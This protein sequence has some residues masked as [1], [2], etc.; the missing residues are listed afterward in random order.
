M[1]R[2]QI[3]R[4]HKL[5]SASAAL[6]AF[7]AGVVMAPASAVSAISVNMFGAYV[8]HTNQ[9]VASFYLM[10]NVTVS[11][12]EASDFS[13]LGSATGCTIEDYFSQSSFHVIN[14]SNCSEGTL[15]LQ[16]GANSVSDGN[17]NWGPELGVVS[18]FMVIDRIAPTIAFGPASS[19]ISGDSINFVA[20]WNEQVSLV[21]TL[22]APAVSGAGCNITSASQ[23]GSSFSFAITACQPGAD[24][25]VTVFANSY[26][27][28]AGNLGPAQDVVS[29]AVVVAA[30]ALPA[31]PLPTASPLPTAEPITEP[32]LAAAPPIEPPA[33][34]APPVAEPEP[35]PAPPV[36]EPESVPTPPVAE[37][38]PVPTPTIELEPIVGF[39]TV[40]LPAAEA[41][42]PSPQAEVMAP[43]PLEPA[44]VIQQ[45]TTFTPETESN[46]SGPKEMQPQEVEVNLSWVAPA[47]TMVATA[48]AAIGAMLF[49]RK[50]LPR[51]ARLR[52]S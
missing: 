13:L 8:S 48:L 35:M 26:S 52:M 40:K 49:L 7:L 3:R 5:L 47:A 6:V 29:Q 28:A 50:R 16:L 12:I 14:V 45:T 44:P 46:V 38:D 24:V 39:V 19:S 20:E 27:D 23:S 30:P 21:D 4:W 36:A 17:S 37:P 32:T 9:P 41:V 42:R 34:P 18:E 51:V 25:Q 10:T 31:L 43:S 22:R 2:K 33:A 15:A 11:D 1:H